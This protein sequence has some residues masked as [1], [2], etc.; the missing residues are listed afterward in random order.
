M[1]SVSAMSTN[2]EVWRG[3]WTEGV[4]ENT[5]MKDILTFLLTTFCDYKNSSEK[6]HVVTTPPCADPTFLSKL[7]S[8]QA[9]LFTSQYYLVQSRFFYFLEFEAPVRGK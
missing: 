2:S 4:A 9:P 6:A 8:L 5:N 1:G 7:T 3:G